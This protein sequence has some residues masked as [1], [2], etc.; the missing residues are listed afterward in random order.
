MADGGVVIHRPARVWPEPAVT[1]PVIVAAPPSAEQRDHGGWAQVLL[2]ALGSIGVLGY[3]VAVRNIAFILMG[4]A[5]AVL[6]PLTAVLLRR[7]QRRAR[8]QQAAAARE[9]YLD[10]LDDR[11]KTLQDVAATQRSA[12][13]LLYP[14]PVDCTHLIRD[15]VRIWERRPG[16][17]DFGTVRLG[18]GRLPLAASVSLESA[19]GPLATP[20]PELA[21]AA[22]RLT[23]QH[24]VL[25]DVPVALDLARLGTIVVIGARRRSRALLR[26]MLV[27]LA[28]S[29]SPRDLLVMG[30]I[31]AEALDQYEWIKWLPH[32]R[33]AGVGGDPGPPALT[34]DPEEFAARI[35][36]LVRERVHQVGR[37]REAREAGPPASEHVV[38]LLDGFEPHAPPATTTALGQLLAQA[39]VLRTSVVVL[40]D[41][42][43]QAPTSAGAML[44]IDADGALWVTEAGPQGLRRTVA[45]PDGL[46][47]RQAEEI[48]RLLAPLRSAEVTGA[49]ERS[50]PIRLLDLLGVDADHVDV[51]SAWRPLKRPEL[52]RVPFGLRD[53]GGRAVLDLKEPAEGGMGP[54]GLVVGAT[55]SGKSE[56]LR[57]L[58]T[59][60]AL[61][62]S[63]E[64]VTFVI[65]DFKGGAAFAALS[66]LPHIAGMVT[67]LVDDPTMVDRVAAA[68]SG[69]LKRRQRVLRRAGNLD[70]IRAYQATRTDRPEL[71]LPEDSGMTEMEVVVGRLSAGSGQAG[72]GRAHQVW[73]PPLPAT[74]PLDAVLDAR[75]RGRHGDLRAAVGLLDRPAEQ[76]QSPLVLDLAGGGGNVAVVGAPQTGKSTFLRTLIASLALT[77]HPRDMQVYAIDLGGGSL[78]ALGGLPHVGTVCSRWERETVGRVVRQVGAL[79][80]ERTLSFPTLGADS[81]VTYRAWRR[82]GAVPE[83]PYGDVLLVIDNWALLRA[84]FEELEQPITEIASSGL[85]YGVHVILASGRWA[86]L[87]PALKESFENRL[88]LRLNDPLESDVG[89]MAGVALRDQPAGRGL[90]RD[91]LRVQVALP[92]IDGRAETSGLVAAQEQL[93]YDVSGRAAGCAAPPVRLLPRLLALPAHPPC[94]SDG[95]LLGVEELG[96]DQVCL[97]LFGDE[98]HLLV[99][100][101]GGSGKT[102]LLRALLRQLQP[103]RRRGELRVHVIDQRRTMIEAADQVDGYAWNPLAAEDLAD[104]LRAELCA[105]LPTGRVALADLR[106]G[107]WWEGP[108]HVLL[109]DDYD[110][111]VTG[112][113]SPI[114]PLADHL[115]LARDVGMHIVLARRA[116]GAVRTS[117]EPVVQRLCELGVPGLLLSGD[118]AEG[119]LHGGVR[120]QPQPPGRGLLVRRGRRTALVQT[121]YAEP[122]EDSGPTT[123]PPP[124][125]PPRQPPR[126]E[127]RPG[128]PQG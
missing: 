10:H 32:A 54:H 44:G 78:H 11:D 84:E 59:A 95:P 37:L 39:A 77:H 105:R 79:L 87:R 61:R 14:D 26:A 123:P 24:A 110:V 60:L 23:S 68:L 94:S 117:F 109:V 91:G 103:G 101:D 100:G 102:T 96:L 41:A 2:P 97:D 21:D 69:E 18:R 4:V 88:E 115:A 49:R 42:L 128:R 22:R 25:D 112:M 114:A 74:L 99:L 93:V 80:E 120:A 108:R 98:P 56:L 6:S 76:E 40:V 53:D 62:H 72:H 73:L 118:P 8:R 34:P 28:T 82:A 50:G 12:A 45:R 52:L 57:N 27:G 127:P 75:P 126:A 86:D 121:V 71:A 20:E 66:E 48:A 65:V 19:G 85:Q 16:D 46:D 17:P 106:R 83:S 119:P 35:T 113:G 47:A 5:M 70:G 58:V 29:H 63:P 81:M 90:T 111:L 125:P 107:R 43:E 3:A 33:S 55:G 104:R 51:R 122:D 1:A 13:E 31:P 116:G 124:P 9:R 36:E 7:G 15:R 92:R 38:V 64:L 67:N 89:R 30:L